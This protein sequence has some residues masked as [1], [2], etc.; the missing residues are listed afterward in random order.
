M[1][2]NHTRKVR[3]PEAALETFCV[4]MSKKLLKHHI[5]ISVLNAEKKN[6]PNETPLAF[7][8]PEHVHDTMEEASGDKPGAHFSRL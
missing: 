1:R 8:I 5:H 3:G 7:L 2:K 6:K 4:L